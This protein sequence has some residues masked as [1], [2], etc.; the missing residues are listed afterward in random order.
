MTR[1]DVDLDPANLIVAVDAMG[2]A[3]LERTARAV[4]AGYA[5]VAEAPGA[6]L[7]E[8]MIA[9]SKSGASTPRTV[10]VCT[11]NCPSQRDHWV[12][13]LDDARDADLAYDAEPRQFRDAVF[14]AAEELHNVRHA[15]T[16]ATGPGA[17]TEAAEGPDRADFIVRRYRG[18][19]AR[20]AAWLE[21]ARAG[22]IDAAAIRR[23]RRRNGFGGELGEPA[24]PP[25]ELADDVLTLHR[26]GA[27]DREI[28]RAVDIG[29][30]AV[31]SIL[32]GQR[33][34]LTQGENS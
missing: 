3:L 11:C 8:T 27:S 5:L 19:P 1:V 2:W 21:T 12:R 17:V 32:D 10:P 6:Q 16:T 20:R 22:H 31:A 26:T 13:R 7:R 14:Q 23:T 24:A 18:V 15:R 28:A 9:R 29:R 30:Q 4:L 34:V 25:A 33:T